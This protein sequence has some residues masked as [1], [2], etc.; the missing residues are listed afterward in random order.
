MRKL[1]IGPLPLPTSGASVPFNVSD[2]VAFSLWVEGTFSATYNLQ[3]SLNGT[4]YILL[5]GGAPITGAGMW[6]WSPRGVVGNGPIGIPS[7]IRV[8]TVSYT[9]GSGTYYWVKEVDR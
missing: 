6:T 7:L 2:A 3:G 4:S 5:P 9:S 1:V 8:A